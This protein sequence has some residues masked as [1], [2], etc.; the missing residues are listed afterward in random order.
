MA[1]LSVTKPEEE[2]IWTAN[3]PRG[4]EDTPFLACQGRVEVNIFSAGCAELMIIKGKLQ[5]C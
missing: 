5:L 3:Q 4:E 2:F 1:V